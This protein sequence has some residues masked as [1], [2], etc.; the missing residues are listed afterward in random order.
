MKNEKIVAIDTEYDAVTK[1]PFLC[2]MHDGHSSLLLYPSND[3][4]WGYIRWICMSCDIKKIFHSATS[5]MYALHQIGINVKPPYEDTFIMSSI[6]DENFS[7][8]KLKDLAKKYLSE[9]CNEAKELT[10][11]RAQYRKKLGKNFSWSLIPKNIIEPYAVKDAEYTYDLW[12]YFEPK[13][14][15]YADLYKLEI[16]LIPLILS[17]TLRG[18]AIDR[19]FCKHEIET[20]NKFWE[21]SYR[22]LCHHYGKLLNTD[23]PADVRELLAS[24]G[25]IINDRTETGLVQTSKNVLE[26]LIDSY[27]VIRNLLICRQASK[28][29]HTYYEP[30]VREY[31]DE[32]DNI[33][34]FAFYQS[35]TKSGRFSAELIQTI[36]K[37]KSET[38]LE[39]NVRRAF[40]PRPGFTNF[41]FDYD[42]IEMRLFAHF[43]KNE[44]IIQAIKNGLD[45]HES[46]AVD[47]YGRE[48]YESD[49][50]RYRQYAKTINFGIIYGMGSTQLAKKL[51]L[52]L[53]EA[54]IILSRYD[55]K[56][57]IRSFI[58]TMTSLL[59]RQGYISLEWINR[60]YRVPR[61]LSY[62][63]V[64]IL[65][66]GS[67]AY[68]IKLAM[69]KIG[70]YILQFDGYVN[71]LVQMHDELI[72]EIHNSLNPIPIVKKI[73]DIMADSST[74]RVPITTSVEYSHVSWGEKKKWK[75]EV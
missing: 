64:N 37:E 74:F 18:H 69:K 73:Q 10:K 47:L 27:P 5:D 1:I 55:Q 17:M 32:F 56:Y 15:A 31:T 19:L 65:I 16:E 45:V 51:A 52:P 9:P 25:I 70:G 59:Y 48:Q 11:I 49:P 36:P 3:F 50:K 57:H 22:K 40:I 67:A 66:Q 60:E 28:Q 75:V 26:P 33:A 71:L 46:T 20:L 35:G 23:S 7:S 61:N 68:I 43:T 29:V 62:K 12:R 2:S 8:R 6:I 39:N 41:Y 58:N 44:K 14:K 42:Q 13:I 54:Y 30:L 38:L 63:C 72:F 53:T 4:D 24:E 34:H 21:Y